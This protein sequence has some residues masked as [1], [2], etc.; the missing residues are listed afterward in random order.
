MPLVAWIPKGIWQWL[1]HYTVTCR[2]DLKKRVW[3]GWLDLLHLIH[4]QLGTIGN[5]A[6]SLIYTLCSSPLHTH[7][8]SQSSLGVSRQRIYNSRTVMHLL[9]NCQFWG[10]DSTEFL[11]FQAHILAGWLPETG[12]ILYCSCWTLLYNHF[13]RT[14]QKRQPL[15]LRRPVYRPVT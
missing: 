12:S 10:L 13:E 6:L 5:I 15:L 14:T 9:R 7:Y 1:I 2:G 11:C 3:I 8:G 4:S